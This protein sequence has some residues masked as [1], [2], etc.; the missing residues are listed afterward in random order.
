M[1]LRGW[2]FNGQQYPNAIHM[3]VTRPQ[4]QPGVVEAFAA[5]LAE[6][7]AYA[8]EHRDEAPK[9]AAVYGGVV[10]GMTEEA[11]EFIRTLM[12]DMMDKH[13]GIPG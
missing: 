7:V 6:A 12:A 3:A 13:Q 4:T 9:S 2:R 5:D 10:G 8:I 1:K 11:D